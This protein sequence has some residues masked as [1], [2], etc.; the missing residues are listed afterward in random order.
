MKDM[1]LDTMTRIDGGFDFWDFSCGALITFAAAAFL[2]PPTV[3]L[4][5]EL[6]MAAYGACLVAKVT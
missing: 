5:I 6:G 4:G 3:L 1:T 2:S